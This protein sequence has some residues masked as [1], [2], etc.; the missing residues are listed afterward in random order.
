SGDPGASVPFSFQATGMIESAVTPSGFNAVQS[1]TIAAGQVMTYHVTG[2]AGQVIDFDNQGAPN[3]LMFTLTDPKNGQVFST[4]S[5]LDAGPSVLAHSGQYTLT[6][7]GNYSTDTVSYQ[8]SLLSLAGA[9]QPLILGTPTGT[10]QLSPGG[11]AAVY[12][13]SG[14]VGQ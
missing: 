7:K 10:H 8:F 12:S 5:L 4:Y 13:F 2:T 11:A 1:G 14:T 3:N 6:V 9:A